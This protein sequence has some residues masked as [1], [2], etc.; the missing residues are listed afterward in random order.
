MMAQLGVFLGW[1]LRKRMDSLERRTSEI[2]KTMDE[3]IRGF[4]K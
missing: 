4:D 2:E 3:M 1:D